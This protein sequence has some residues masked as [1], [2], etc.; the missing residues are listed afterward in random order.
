[1]ATDDENRFRVEV[2]FSPGAAYN[3]F[4]KRREGYQWLHVL[5]LQPRM[6]LHRDE[7]ITLERLD[8]MLRPYSTPRKVS[9]PF[10]WLTTQ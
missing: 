7:G 4:E 2:L 9:K 8:K 3:P 5:P 10:P 6:K 1:M